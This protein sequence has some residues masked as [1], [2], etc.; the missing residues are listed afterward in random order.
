MPRIIHPF[1]YRAEHL[2]RVVLRR[3]LLLEKA[4]QRG[5]HHDVVANSRDLGEEEESEETSNTAETG[6]HGAAVLCECVFVHVG[7]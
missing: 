6:S 1:L 3:N 7:G 5:P 2:E 4:A